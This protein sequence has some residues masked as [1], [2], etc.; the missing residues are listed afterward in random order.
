[1]FRNLK[2]LSFRTQIIRSVVG[3]VVGIDCIISITSM[4]R[5]IY[6][7]LVLDYNGVK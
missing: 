1:M 6:S 5:M 2:A 7:S 4:G 3:F